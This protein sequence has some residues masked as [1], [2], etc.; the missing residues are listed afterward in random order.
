MWI[1]TSGLV[2]VLELKGSCGENVTDGFGRFVPGLCCEA[3]VYVKSL[4]GCIMVIGL[5]G[6]TPALDRFP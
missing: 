5:D 4:N 1:L 3:S 2:S 6:C